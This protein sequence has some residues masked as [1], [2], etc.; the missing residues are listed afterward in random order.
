MGDTADQRHETSSMPPPPLAGVTLAGGRRRLGAQTQ[1]TPATC[2][3]AILLLYALT[4]T[5][6]LIF[7]VLPA[8]ARGRGGASPLGAMA[9]ARLLA[10]AAACG[11]AA[12]ALEVRHEPAPPGAAAGPVRHDGQRLGGAS[13]VCGAHRGGLRLA[14][15]RV[16]R[17][18]PGQRRQPPAQRRGAQASPPSRRSSPS[19]RSSRSS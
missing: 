13:S 5:P 16:C 2:I 10:L 18:A 4:Y 12:R 6:Y 1:H 7:Y 9:A 3:I 19:P 14:D 8:P 17:L 15:C 11:C